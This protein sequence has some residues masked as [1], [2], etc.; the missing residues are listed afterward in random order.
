MNYFNVL[1][2]I[3]KLTPTIYAMIIKAEQIFTAPKSGTDK[4]AYVQ[5]GVAKAIQAVGV[6]DEFLQQIQPVVQNLIEEGVSEMK[7][8]PAESLSAIDDHLSG[9][10]GA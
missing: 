10:V 6:A 2:L 4:S 7:Q 8:L 5:S 3:V 1:S 9:T